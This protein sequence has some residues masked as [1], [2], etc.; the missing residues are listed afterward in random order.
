MFKR[1]RNRRGGENAVLERIEEKMRDMDEMMERINREM[2]NSQN[3]VTNEVEHEIL[4]FDND[5]HNQGKK[6][7]SRP[8][9]MDKDIFSMMIVSQPNSIAWW[10]GLVIIIFQIVAVILIT[11]EQFVNSTNRSGWNVP[12]QV[13]SYITLGQFIS[14]IILMMISG[15]FVSSIKNLC[16]TLHQCRGEE[17]ENNGNETVETSVVEATVVEATVVEVKKVVQKKEV[18]KKKEVPKKKVPKKTVVIKVKKKE[19]EMEVEVEDGLGLSVAQSD[20]SDSSYFSDSNCSSYSFNSKESKPRHTWTRIVIPSVLHLIVSSLILFASLVVIVR[21]EKIFQLFMNLIVLQVISHCSKLGYRFSKEYS[22]RNGH[23]FGNRIAEAADIVARVQLNHYEPKSWKNIPLYTFFIAFVFTMMIVVWGRVFVLQQNRTYLKQAYSECFQSMGP[24]EFSIVAD[25]TCNGISNNISC[26]YDGGDCID[27]NE[28]WPGCKVLETG[29][30][31]DEK[32][33]GRIGISYNTKQCG[34]DGGDCMKN[35]TA[36]FQDLLGN[37]NC[38][39]I[40]PYNTVECSY[41]GGDCIGFNSKYEDCKCPKNDTT[42]LDADILHMLENG[43]CDNYAP[44]NSRECK[45]DG[46]DCEYFLKD[47]PNCT[48]KESTW[49]G[50]G[51]CHNFHPYNSRECKYD[52]GDCDLF[53]KD[54][55]NCTAKETTLIGDGYCHNIYNT[56]ACGNDGGDCQI[57]TGKNNS[58]SDDS[59]NDDNSTKECS[60][61]RTEWINDG[62]CDNFP[63]YNTPECEYDGGE[64][65]SFNME[66]TDC[67]APYPEYIGDGFCDGFLWNTLECKFDGGDC[68]SFK[69][70]Q[71]EASDYWELGNGRCWDKY[72]YNTLRCGYDGGDCVYLKDPYPDCDITTLPPYFKWYPSSVGDK[73]CEPEFNTIECGWDGGD[74]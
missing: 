15:D 55:P 2:P 34:W 72:P 41:D 33:D 59:K 4:R 27:F 19:K 38:E 44:Y 66:Y 50:D 7:K 71:C 10:Y 73:I 30:I 8:E 47:Y 16:T 56:S 69:Y 36:E 23:S 6:L 65:V 64:C 35:C 62:Y 14:L 22:F 24:T 49:V 20:V 74:C 42:C 40:F 46:G 54:Y 60:A 68:L 39:N 63:P 32:C 58:S 21:S 3:N 70:P 53:L 12:I 25:G 45:N 11:H 61:N 37:G 52:G 26:G 17:D 1:K 29:K 31:G 9:P 18:T 51:H 48:A 43:K 67:K 57:F 13:L 5:E 28:R